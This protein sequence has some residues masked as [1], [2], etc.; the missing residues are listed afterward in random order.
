MSRTAPGYYG[1]TLTEASLGK[2]G[3]TLGSGNE[4]E[5][6]V[7]ESYPHLV[8]KRYRTDLV[9]R[10]AELQPTLKLVQTLAAEKNIGLLE[11]V[12]W[13]V[14]AVTD[15]SGRNVRGV[16]IPRLP[17]EYDLVVRGKKRLC[18]WN[19]AYDHA[20][21]AG[22]IPELDVG[23]RRQL[24]GSIAWILSSLDELGVVLSDIKGENG[25]WN[26]LDPASAVLIDAD[27]ARIGVLI[28]RK[29]PGWEYGPDP[30]VTHADGRVMRY[31]SGLLLGRVLAGSFK[32]PQDPAARRAADCAGGAN[33]REALARLLSVEAD[34]QSL[35][36]IARELGRELPAVVRSSEEHRRKPPAI[37]PRNLSDRQG[38][39]RHAPKAP[40]KKP[41]AATR[42]TPGTNTQ[43]RKYFRSQTIAGIVS[44]V[45]AAGVI[46]LANSLANESDHRSAT[47]NK[48]VKSTR[49]AIRRTIVSHWRNRSIGTT[50]SLKSAFMRYSS[51]QR[52]RSGGLARWSKD[53]RADGRLRVHVSKINV[54]LDG[55]SRAIASA[56]VQTRSSVSGCKNWKIKYLMTLVEGHWLMESMSSK[57]R[58]C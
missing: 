51:D 31:R 40:T 10:L 18:T 44:L 25:V 9:V 19:Y 20:S 16:V 27:A 2:L 28:D 35:R 23:E 5:V 53:I 58:E 14:N 4:A 26:P 43:R 11:R 56:S 13:I 7:L 34:L 22:A 57:A 29:S 54:S 47:G 48:V 15:E 41:G 55:A 32:Y 49:E 6:F 39:E 46:L 8:Y 3:G 42:A 21:G 52:R 37:Q 36:T 33:V 17:S 45:I 30:S 38:A 12:A 24:A 50:R 1:A